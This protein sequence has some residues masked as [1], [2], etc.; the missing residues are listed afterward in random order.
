[1][2]RDG[3]EGGRGEGRGGRR[4]VHRAVAGA[5]FWKSRFCGC[6]ATEELLSIVNV[7]AL[8]AVV[9]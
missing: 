7:P 6:L 8:G 5:F 4:R 2:S 1:M 3:A 9:F